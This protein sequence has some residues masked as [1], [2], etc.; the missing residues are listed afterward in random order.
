MDIKGDLFKE[1]DIEK[2]LYKVCSNAYT[3][4][5]KSLHKK[6]ELSKLRKNGL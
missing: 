6:Y 3:L 1:V 5:I 4:E 2:N